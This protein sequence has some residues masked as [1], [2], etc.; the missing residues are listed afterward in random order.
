MADV[1]PPKSFPKPVRTKRVAVPFASVEIPPTLHFGRPFHLT[2]AEYQTLVAD[3]AFVPRRFWEFML[4]VFGATVA[5]FLAFIA[6]VSGDR[7]FSA[8]ASETVQFALSVVVLLGVYLS[9]R[10]TARKAGPS[11]KTILLHEIE[12]HF[13]RVKLERSNFRTASMSQ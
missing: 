11:K 8:T 9:A 6:M 5:T 2:E 3:D 4:A 13:Q 7:G 1:R 12:T 10:I